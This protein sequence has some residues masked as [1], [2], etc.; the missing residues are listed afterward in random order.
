LYYNTL[1]LQLLQDEA[2]A[3]LGES[4]M[5]VMRGYNRQQWKAYNDGHQ[6]TTGGGGIMSGGGVSSQQSVFAP[7]ASAKEE[8]ASAQSE[9][10]SLLEQGAASYDG[11]SVMGG[12]A[13]GAESQLSN[14]SGRKRNDKVT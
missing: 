14:L 9:T 3:A 5:S 4:N 6:A 8:E 1:S 13:E 7:K 11:Q 10:L 12:E 2:I